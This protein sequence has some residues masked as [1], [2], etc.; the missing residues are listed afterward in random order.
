MVRRGKP[1]GKLERRDKMRYRT[2]GGRAAPGE[3]REREGTAMFRAMRR[4]AQQIPEEECR[5]VLENAKTGVLGVIGDDGYPYTVPLNFVYQRGNEGSLGTIGF[6][7]A[8]TGHKID[9]IRGC[10]RVSFTVIDRDEVMPRERTT[11]YR[12]VIAFG[13]A[14]F[15]EGEENL[16]RAANAVG[17]KY[18]AGFEDLYMAETEECIARDVLCCVEIEI[19]YMTGK[20]GREL[21]M[22]RKAQEKA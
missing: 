18:S 21:L 5:Q 9:A 11:K 6:H 17:A 19:E 2:P 20:I 14:R 10:D 13:R 8:K 7:C 16:R 15:V 22:E 1:V 12:S 4:A 3:K